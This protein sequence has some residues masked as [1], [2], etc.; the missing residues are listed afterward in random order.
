MKLKEINGKHYQECEVVILS[1]KDNHSQLE[2]DNLSINK[3]SF[4]LKQYTCKNPQHLYIVSNEKIKEGDYFL[5]DIRNHISENNS[6]PIWKLK[7]CSKIDNGWIFNINNFGLGYNPNWCKKIIATT[8]SSLLI[9]PYE[10]KA[11]DVNKIRTK[12]PQPPESFI[13]KFIKS[14]NEGNPITKVLVE[15]IIGQGFENGKTQSIKEY[16]K[17]GKSNEITIIKSKIWTKEEKDEIVNIHIEIMK[18]GLIE[19]GGDIAWK[20]EYESKIREIATNWIEQNL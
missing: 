8:D 2:I 15:Y 17:V 14:Y 20:D 3:L 12:Y 13:A 19:E 9:T 11:E 1:T 6:N 18:V 7:Q 16:L 5:T 4:E 10:W